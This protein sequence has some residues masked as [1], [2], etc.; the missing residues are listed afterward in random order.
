MINRYR[1]R[2][3][4]TVDWFNTDIHTSSSWIINSVPIL[5]IL[6]SPGFGVDSNVIRFTL[7]ARNQ[8]TYTYEMFQFFLLTSSI[9]FWDYYFL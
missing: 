6:F 1:P 8:L 5:T 7:F 9:N 3:N 4:D 2:L